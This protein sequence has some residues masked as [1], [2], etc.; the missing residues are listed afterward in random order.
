MPYSIFNRSSRLRAP[1]PGD[2]R[3]DASAEVQHD[4]HLARDIGLP[5]RPLPRRRTEAW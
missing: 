1:V 2:L 5:Y 3:C 4:A